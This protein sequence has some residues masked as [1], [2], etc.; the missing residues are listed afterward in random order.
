MVMQSLVDTMRTETPDPS[1]IAAHLLEIKDPST[2]FLP[3]VA[4]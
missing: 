4:R 3:V 2:G 1:S